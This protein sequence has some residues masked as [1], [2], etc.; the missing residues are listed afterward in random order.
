MYLIGLKNTTSQALAVGD[1]INFGSVYRRFD[2]KGAC[3]LR[4]FESNNTDLIIQHSGIYKVTATITFTAP[5]TGDVTFQLFENGVGIAGA[6]VTESV[7]TA[8]TEFHT[9][10]L[11]YYV[12]ADKDL[13]LNSVTN[14]AE[15]LSIANVGVASTV[16]NVILN[17]FKGV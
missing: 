7:E 6:T 2:K 5:A 17:V 13:V 10:T 16:T 4:A 8:T 11:D 1:F 3:G 14:V 12:L 9:V 15:T